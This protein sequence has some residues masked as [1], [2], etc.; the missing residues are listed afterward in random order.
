MS[1][2][3]QFPTTIFSL[4]AFLAISM[5]FLVVRPAHAATNRYVVNPGHCANFP[6]FTPCY[7]SIL[8][9]GNA[10]TAGDTLI[11]LENMNYG[12]AFSDAFVTSGLTLKGNNSNGTI[13]LPS[14][15]V[16]TANNLIIQDFTITDAI[17]VRNVT[18][19]VRMQNITAKGL[20]VQP[21]TDLNA[22]LEFVNNKLPQTQSC[23]GFYCDLSILGADGKNINGTITIQGNTVGAI[24]V[25]ANVAT[26]GT[27]TLGANVTLDG[28]NIQDTVNVGIT[29]SG[30]QTFKG[31][32]NI[33]GNITFNNNQVNNTSHGLNVTVDTNTHGNI[34]GNITFSNNI[35]DKIACITFDADASFSNSMSGSLYVNGNTGENVEVG[36]R[37]DFT[38]TDL[39]VQNNNLTYKGSVDGT[40]VTVRANHF[41]SN[42]TIRVGD[43]TGRFG[44]VF[45]TFTGANDAVASIYRNPTHF[46]VYNVATTHAGTFSITDN[47]INGPYPP[48]PPG[49]P[50]WG[51]IVAVSD[52]GPIN[53]ANILN[54][55]GDNIYL[56][57]GSNIAGNVL[58]QG[59][60]LTGTSIFV[61]NGAVG[62]GKIT[63]NYNRLGTI[64]SDSLNFTRI[65]AD[66]NF[67]AIMGPLY[68]TS[69]TVNALRNWWGCN[70]GPGV[71]FGPSVP[72]SNP[73]LVFTAN[74]V[75]SSANN[76]IF[77]GYYVNK[78][79]NGT[80]WSNIT[81]PGNVNVTTSTGSVA[82]PNPKAL[83][84]GFS[85]NSSLVNVSASATANLTATLDFQAQSISNK[86][87]ITRTDTIGI[88]R[89][90]TGAW[91]LNTAND[92]SA[93]EINATYG[94]STWQPVVGDWD[95]DGVDTLGGYDQTTGVFYLRNTNSTGSPDKSL[96]LGNPNDTPIA[97]RWD[98]TMTITGVGV[99]RPSN[100]IIYLKREL[101]TGFSDYFMI[102]GNPG[103]RGFAG[104][105]DG[106]GY[107]GPGV[108]RPSLGR[109]Y[110]SNNGTASGIIVDDG[111]ADF[112]PANDNN[113]RP[114][115]GDWNADGVSGIGYLLNGTFSLRN[116]PTGNGTANLGF[117]FGSAGDYPI[118]GHWTSA[119]YD[120]SQA[121]LNG[122]LVQP[123]TTSANIDQ[124]G[125]GD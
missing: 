53:N 96:V 30:G 9:A 5:M 8:S 67:N 83:K 100:G 38:G 85:W 36:F 81:I 105:W 10:S 29:H 87:C 66:V 23:S 84:A 61:A 41:S 73:W 33:T 119:T 79:S 111:F 47:T 3:K 22:T 70:G 24:N 15:Q 77:V 125:T 34:S 7:T 49:N 1:R 16:A 18:T 21:T 43:N 114:V 103:D 69:S 55:V 101:T 121:N 88:F 45:D 63:M 14:L 123:G 58:M 11:V 54:N 109:W 82:A 27:A 93:A 116:A 37:G 20:Y 99:F 120:Q 86:Q 122:L 39:N 97:G 102:L 26:T 50:D 56:Q 62:P 42:T 72:T 106:D 32:G 12:L 98:P 17:I 107:D 95:G 68:P 46:I 65:N 94:G 124:I 31:A 80:L 117:A 40:V 51:R 13:T 60:T 108:F 64:A 78:D 104:D 25:F 90:S 52:T 75:C 44:I 48:N 6:A 4:I 92:S 115:I 91:A 28:N 74:A 71:C 113:L 110:L 76:K 2:Q 35:A 19:K 118:A 112:G 89:S 59:N 57:A